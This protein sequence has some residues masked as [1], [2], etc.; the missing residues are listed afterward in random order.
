MHTHLQ[1]TEHAQMPGKKRDVQ[2]LAMVLDPLHMRGNYVNKS[3]NTNV[4]IA[5]RMGVHAWPDL[6][7]ADIN[8]AHLMEHFKFT[9]I[10]FSFF[11]SLHVN[12]IFHLKA[13][14]T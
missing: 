9:V 10:S 13:F 7:K 1:G 8:K 3:R 12:Q 14:I 6:S 5:H 11:I 2:K 4:L